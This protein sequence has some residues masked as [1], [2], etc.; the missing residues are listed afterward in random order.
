MNKIA[1]FNRRRRLFLSLVIGTGVLGL[2]GLFEAL[3]L[4]G[5][6]LSARL[7]LA[8]LFAMTFSWISVSFWHAVIG[9]VLDAY[10]P[11]PLYLAVGAQSRARGGA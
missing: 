4:A 6:S 2:V 3:V 11:K 7:P 10:A 8:F 5:V 1:S 9:F